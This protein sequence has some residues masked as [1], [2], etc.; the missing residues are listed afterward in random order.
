[1]Q[2]CGRNVKIILQLCQNMPHLLASWPA[3]SKRISKFYV[4]FQPI[5]VV[6]YS[7]PSSGY[8]VNRSDSHQLLE[9]TYATLPLQPVHFTQIT[10]KTEPCPPEARNTCP[11]AQKWGSSVPTNTISCSSTCPCRELSALELSPSTPSPP[12]LSPGMFPLILLFFSV[13]FNVLLRTLSGCSPRRTW[14]ALSWPAPPLAPGSTC[15]IG[16][17]CSQHQRSS[18]FRTGDKQFSLLYNIIIIYMPFTFF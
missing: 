7:W 9:K 2:F 17:T 4:K 3:K 16:S 10:K 14:R 18:S 5:G 15:T 12:M 8:Y 13:N 6:S 1:M 11:S